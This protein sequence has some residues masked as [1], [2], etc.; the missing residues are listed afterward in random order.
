MPSAR[1]AQHAL[2]VHAAFSSL[3]CPSL[4]DRRAQSTNWSIGAWC[5]FPDCASESVAAPVPSGCSGKTSNDV[6]SEHR[7]NVDIRPILHAEHDSNDATDYMADPQTNAHSDEF[8][9]HLIVLH[10]VKQ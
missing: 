8:P 1:K 4:V 9:D 6:N 7:V 5:G 2:H 3:Q 10:P